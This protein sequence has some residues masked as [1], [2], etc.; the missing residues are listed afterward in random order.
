MKRRE[1][2]WRQSSR[3]ISEAELARI[4]AGVNP[5]VAKVLE[6][7]L[8][9]KDLNETEGEILARVQGEELEALVITANLLRKRAIGDTVTY[10]VNRNINFTNICSGNCG[11]CA[12]RVAPES[13]EALLYSLEEIGR[14]AREAWE[15]GATEVCIQGGLH[16]DLN[17]NYYRDI[18]LTVKES[19][20]QIHIHAFSPMEITYGAEKAGMPVREYLTILREAGLDSMPGTAAEILVPEVRKIIAPKKMG[21]EKW[22]EVIRSAHKLG[23][24]TSSTILY[25]HIEHP[26]H[27]VKHILLLRSIQQETGGFTELVPLGFVHPNTLLYREGLSR[28]G[29]LLE[30]HLKVHALSRLLLKGW[31]NHV[32]VSWVKMGPKVSQL[33]LKGGADDFGGTLMEESISR[34]AG[35]KQ[36]ENMNPEMFRKLIWEIGR[37]PAQRSTTYAILNR[38]PLPSTP[39]AAE[40]AFGKHA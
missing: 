29:P 36:G 16:P 1:A 14:R 17:P 12:F 24:P 27:W 35:A 37:I 7:A 10:I 8:G 30:E 20:P 40:C 11:F 13:P 31:I 19:A 34:L 21:V 23:I 5:L 25:G 9:S 18:L 6:K 4:I 22:V 3:E 32:Q 39:S 28:P 2:I 26:E 33:C 15:R 38:F